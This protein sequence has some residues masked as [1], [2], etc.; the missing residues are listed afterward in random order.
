MKPYFARLAA[1]LAALALTLPAFAQTTPAADPLSAEPDVRQEVVY[2]DDSCSEAIG[3]EILTCIILVEGERYRIPEILRGDP[4]N[5]RNE[6]W[7]NKIA[8]IER[9]SR[10]GTESCSASGLG[11][12]TGCGIQEIREAYAE[13][14]Q[15]DATSWSALIS[16]ERQKRIDAIDENARRA[17]AAVQAQEATRE[18]REAEMAAARARLAAEEAARQNPP[19]PPN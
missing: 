9:I 19:P 10:F 11:G 17:E 1:A 2:G 5:P 13:L 18:A 16:A 15:R 3:D 6:A 4:N 7:A 8:R 14:A 12:F